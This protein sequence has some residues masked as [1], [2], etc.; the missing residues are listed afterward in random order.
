MRKK[1]IKQTA[2]LMAMA[3]TASSLHTGMAVE[4]HTVDYTKAVK[5]LGY[6]LQVGTTEEEVTYNQENTETTSGEDITRE[7]ETNESASG[8][9]ESGKAGTGETESGETESVTDETTSEETTSPEETTPP[10][11]I[12]VDNVYKIRQATG[13]LVQYLGDKNDA[14][15]KEL[16]IPANVRIIEKEVFADS[17]YIEIVK[18]ESGSK[19][20]T[21]GDNAFNGCLALKIIQLPEGLENMGTRTFGKCLALTE[22]TIPSTVISGIE[23]F[24]TQNAVKKVTFA[25]GMITVPEY[26]L[27]YAYSVQQIVLNEG[28]KTIGRQA[29]YKCKSLNNVVIPSTVTTLKASAFNGCTALTSVYLP[30]GLK[31]ISTNAF[32]NC[33]GLLTLEIPKKTTSIGNNAFKGDIVIVLKVYANSKGKA[34]AR[35]NNIKW[36]FADSEIKRQAANTAIYNNYVSKIRKKDRAKFDM[37][38]YLKNYV[39]QGTCIIGKY[40]VVSMYYKKMKKNSVIVLYNRYTGA[41]VKKLTLPSKDH[42]GAV[43]NVKGRLV[44]SLNNI[45]ATDY[46]A[47]VSLSKLNNTKNGKKLKY[48]YKVKLSGYADFAAFDGYVFWAGRSANINTATMQGYRVKIINKKLTFTKQFSFT[49]PANAQGLVV[50][51]SANSSQRTFTF[52]QS[53]GRL[54][55]SK[56]LTYIAKVKKVKTLGDVKSEITLPSMLE[57]IALSEKGYMFMTYESGAGLYC[58]NPDNTSEIQI[59]NVCQIKYSKL[60]KL[61]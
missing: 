15:I 56:L 20:V 52:A 1:F 54:N 25:Q 14:G 18:F 3:M 34:Y 43:T 55:N 7:D 6:V 41:F 46:V 44:I 23:I 16:T 4:A 58:G 36:E 37:T 60:D 42:V 48:D 31:T 32:K 38:P 27:K 22:F 21:I 2:I 11:F 5:Q 49:V 51:K 10:E 30:T 26:I 57:G 61:K 13:E 12:V 33:T 28:L 35:A 19:L 8:E 24:G 45:S 39:P 9:T 29:F 17:K 50:K 40:I 47:V 59:N 53:Y